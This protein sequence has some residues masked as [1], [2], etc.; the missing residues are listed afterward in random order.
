MAVKGANREQGYNK[1]TGANVT[2]ATV[3]SIGPA[4]QGGVQGCD[5][6]RT[7]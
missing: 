1:A 6:Q 3:V 5:N 7:D 2:V 4:A